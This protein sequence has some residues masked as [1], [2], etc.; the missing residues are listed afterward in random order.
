[1]ECIFSAKECYVLLE[2]INVFVYVFVASLISD[3]S[4]KTTGQPLKM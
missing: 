1:M 3:I 2:L 4:L